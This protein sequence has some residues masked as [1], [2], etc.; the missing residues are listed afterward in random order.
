MTVKAPY[1]PQGFGGVVAPG[2]RAVA[3]H[4]S[5]GGHARGDARHRVLDDEAPG[6][7]HPQRCGRGQVHV[8]RR[9]GAGH[10]V[11]AEHAP[12]EVRQQSHLRKLQLHLVPVGAGC[13]SDAP[14]RA[15]VRRLHGLPRARNGLQ[16]RSQ[17][18]IAPL[19]EKGHPLVRQRTARLRLDPGGFAAHGLADED[20]HALLERERPSGL[21]Q[22]GTQHAVGDRLAV[23]QH[24]VAIEQHG[25]ERRKRPGPGGRGQRQGVG[26]H[27][28]DRSVE[29]ARQKAAPAWS[30]AKHNRI[31]R[32]R[33]WRPQDGTRC[34]AT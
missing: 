8:R 32:M 4:G 6:G 7:R 31:Y 24:A 19:I 13:A 16:L 18:G 3:H 5:P 34:A 26:G 15:G 9:L 1:R 28:R 20:A 29:S 21:L 11:P 17:R 33:A 12:L 25:A 10:L 2:R 30:A 23:H 14:R 22:H 27:G